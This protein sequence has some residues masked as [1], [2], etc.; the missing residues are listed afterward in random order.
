M[1]DNLKTEYPSHTSYA[2]GI[3]SS[4]KPNLYLVDINVYAKL[5]QILLILRYWA[6]TSSPK[7]NDRSPESNVPR[8]NLISKN[9]NSSKL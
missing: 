4:V 8:S 3:K 6:E 7:G 9:S 2:E 5:G 1:T